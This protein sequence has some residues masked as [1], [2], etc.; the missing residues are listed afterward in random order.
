MHRI[1]FL[2]GDGFQIRSLAPQTEEQRNAF[3]F[4]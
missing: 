2:P 4:F 3:G 1:G